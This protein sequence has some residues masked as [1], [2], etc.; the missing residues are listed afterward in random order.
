MTQQQMVAAGFNPTVDIQNLR[1][2]VDATEV[3]I[4]TNQFSGHFGSGDYI[5]FY[6]RGL[7]TPTTDTRIYYLTA[8]TT[9]GKR[10]RGQLQLDEDPLDPPGPTSTPL[11]TSIP[12]ASTPITPTS[13]GPLLRDPVFFSWAD[14]GLRLMWE[15]LSKAPITASRDSDAQRTRIIP[16]TNSTPDKTSPDNSPPEGGQAISTHELKPEREQSARAGGSSKRNDLA[17]LARVV[18]D[19]AISTPPKAIK[20]NASTS[21]RA[22]VTG[23]QLQKRRKGKKASG[24]DCD[25]GSGRSATTL[26]SVVALRRQISIT[27]LRLRIGWFTFP[28]Y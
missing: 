19:A 16:N 7:D 14:H 24:A 18:N 20:S 4:N 11:P 2:F 10:V 8:G 3:A 9:A 5:E 23:R 15:S 21:P 28:V 6:G 26:L 27:Q 13:T 22:L 25:A 17:P 1:L 12:P